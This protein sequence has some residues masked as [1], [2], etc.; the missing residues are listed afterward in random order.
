M[1]NKVPQY[2]SLRVAVE[3]TL[4]HTVHYGEGRIQ[5]VD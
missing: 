1:G 5:R 4:G 2:E 3:P